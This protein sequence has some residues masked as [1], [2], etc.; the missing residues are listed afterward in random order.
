MICAVTQKESA[1]YDCARMILFDE[2][3]PDNAHYLCMSGEDDTP[4][5][6]MCWDRYLRGVAAG[7]IEMPKRKRGAAL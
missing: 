7:A 5:C 1:L 6:A 2:C 3:P 4:D